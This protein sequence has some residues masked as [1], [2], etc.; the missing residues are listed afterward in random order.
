MTQRGLDI[1]RRD[2][3]IRTDPDRRRA[4]AQ[5]HRSLSLRAA[6]GER[7]C[8]PRQDDRQHAPASHA[9]NDPHQRAL[10]ALFTA[11]GEGGGQLTMIALSAA[12]CE[13]LCVLVTDQHASPVPATLPRFGIVRLTAGMSPRTVGLSPPPMPA[14]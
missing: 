14:E 10:A 7:S 3:H 2:R 13:L 6:G 1:H 8:A 4:R 12:I 5:G 11:R 9:V